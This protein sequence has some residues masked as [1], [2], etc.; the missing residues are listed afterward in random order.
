MTRDHIPELFQIEGA[1][2]DCTSIAGAADS[3]KTSMWPLACMQAT[4]S[5]AARIGGELARRLTRLN[6]CPSALMADAYQLPIATPAGHIARSAMVRELVR[7][8]A[9]G[10]QNDTDADE[11]ASEAASWI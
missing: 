1:A 10:V 6:E 7:L 5:E 2:F 8:A 3:I 4:P 11:S 9:I